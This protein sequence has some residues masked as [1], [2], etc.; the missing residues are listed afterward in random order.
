MNSFKTIGFTNIT[1]EPVKDIY[2][3]ITPEG[4]V[5]KVSIDGK[6]LKLDSTFNDIIKDFSLY[7]TIG[8]YDID[9]LIQYKKYSD[10]MA[11]VYD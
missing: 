7:T 6:I 1:F 4:E 5:S 9:A 10:E 2:F 3:G 11:S 8:K